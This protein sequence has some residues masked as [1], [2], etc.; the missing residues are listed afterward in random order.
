MYAVF[1]SHLTTK[2]KKPA[3]KE[4]KITGEKKNHI[5]VRIRRK[6]CSLIGICTYMTFP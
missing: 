2:H 3:K 4:S 6:K 5:P 1:L